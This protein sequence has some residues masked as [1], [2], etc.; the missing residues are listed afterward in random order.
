MLPGRLTMAAHCFLRDG[1]NAENNV[2]IVRSIKSVPLL[3]LCGI[4]LRFVF[5][6][7]V[8]FIGKGFVFEVSAKEVSM[9]FFYV[10]VLAED[11]KKLKKP[12]GVDLRLQM[13]MHMERTSLP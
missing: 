13:G 5:Y 10:L 9:S 3:L 1:I 7:S 8:Y 2:S 11:I 4:L 12:C 6:L